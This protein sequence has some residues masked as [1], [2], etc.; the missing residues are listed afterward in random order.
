[1]RRQVIGSAAIA[2]LLLTGC[3]GGEEQKKDDTAA[4]QSQKAK[5]TSLEDVKVSGDV[6]KK[7]KIEF[8]TPFAVKKSE[9]KVYSEGDGA[10]IKDGDQVTANVTTLEGTDRDKVQSTY[11]QGKPYGFPM[12]D[13]QVQKELVDALVGAKVGSRVGLA[14]PTENGATV[15]HIVDVLKSEKL[16]T[17]A[18]GKE[19]PQ[20]KDLPQVSRDK[21]GKPSITEPKGKPPKELVVEPVIEGDGKKV[22]KDQEVTVQYSGWLWDDASKTFDSSWEK[23]QPTTFGLDGVIKGWTE[24]LEGQKVGS[25]VLLVT[26][27]DKAYG[28]QGM[29]PNI[30]PNKTLVFVV[31]IL[32]AN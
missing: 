31:D 14:I 27:P 8:D 5:A 10:V 19:L 30:G 7:P 16:K 6:D 32:A 11:D 24:G 26:P 4:E 9:T 29:P 17:R 23:G 3:S 25:Q 18:E 13:N 20:K 12:D 28:E 2:A 1:M 15:L 21:D 22:E